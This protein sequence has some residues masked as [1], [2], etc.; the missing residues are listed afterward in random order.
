MNFLLKNYDLMMG[1]AK[2]LFACEIFLK[3]QKLHQVI[4][5][6]GK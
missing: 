5:L 6:L 1:L 2:T 4:L 3:K